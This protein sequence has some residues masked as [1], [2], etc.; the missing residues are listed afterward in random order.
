MCT[1]WGPGLDASS[2]PVNLGEGG[3]PRGCF[4]N[5]LPDTGADGVLE[6]R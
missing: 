2:D 1:A 4:S 5:S 6:Y 3:E